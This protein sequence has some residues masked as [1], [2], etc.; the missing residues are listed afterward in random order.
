MEE[1]KTEIVYWWFGFI[2]GI[3]VTISALTCH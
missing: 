2:S 3:I 1:T